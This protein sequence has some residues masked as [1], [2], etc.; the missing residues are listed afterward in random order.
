MSVVARRFRTR[1]VPALVVALGVALLATGLLSY[2]SAVEPPFVAQALES[3]DPLPTIDVATLPG[4]SLAPGSAFPKDRVATRIVV[5]R[6]DIDMPVIL[7]EGAEDRFGTYPLC[8][9]AMYLPFLG[10]PGQGRA[11]YIYAHAQP[12]MFLPLYIA[13][14]TNNGKRLLGYAVYVYTSDNF[15]FEYRISSLLLHA[16]N[17]NDA[18]ATTTE[19]LF[20]QTSEGPHGTV[21]K[22]QVLASY[23]SQKAVEPK[24]AHPAAHPRQCGY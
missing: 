17:L 13:S 20:M 10:Q 16:T 1:L 22:L 7:Q 12:S 11:T 3:Y 2:T 24:E 6:L 4:G 23:V 9:V 15:V 5:P 18:F 21:A 19:M 14:L 8:D